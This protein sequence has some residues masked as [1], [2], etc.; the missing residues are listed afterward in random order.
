MKFKSWSD[1]NKNAI[2]ALRPH[3][4]LRQWVDLSYDEKD[5]IIKYFL[6]KNW[7]DVEYNNKT[8]PAVLTLNEKFKIKSYG[9]ATLNHGGPHFSQS[10]NGYRH[11][12]SCCYSFAQTDVIKILKEEHS[13]V[14]YELLS[15]YAAHL[16]ENNFSSFKN[17]FNDISEQFYLNILMTA[18]HLVPKQDEKI[19]EEIYE[20]VLTFLAEEQWTPVNNDLRDAFADYFKS[21]PEGYSA[22]V[23]HAI[24][25]LQG[26]LQIQIYGKAGKGTIDAL[27]AEAVKK[28]I[29][30]ES[31]LA[32]NLFKKVFD[33]LMKERQT[34]GDAHPKNRYA[35]EKSARL[36]LNLVMSILQ[37]LIQ[38]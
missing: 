16:E 28:N 4:E 36:T 8:L 22:S 38:S 1:S 11:Q 26:F 37:S 10:M 18:S 5:T 33:E 19:T 34:V 2:D 20:P 27:L 3:F 30:Q 23:T 6:N 32:H 31:S 7:F 25:A 13:D 29:I 14:V 35:D 24:S 21:T 9:Q 15:I 17:L 12:E